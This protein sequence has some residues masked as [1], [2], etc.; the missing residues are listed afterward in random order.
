MFTRF[1]SCMGQFLEHEDGASPVEYAIIA[2]LIVVVCATA[3]WDM[4]QRSGDTF[5]T[6]RSTIQ[7]AQASH[8][9]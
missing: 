4:G 9:S 5:R 3:V 7:A 8:G 6:V 1:P 2:A